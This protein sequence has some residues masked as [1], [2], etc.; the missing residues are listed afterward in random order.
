MCPSI[1]EVKDIIL[2]NGVLVLRGVPNKA[3]TGS[4]GTSIPDI[5]LKDLKMSVKDLNRRGGQ[6]MW[7]R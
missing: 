6:N 7:T 5:S 1:R 2:L 4:S 3:V